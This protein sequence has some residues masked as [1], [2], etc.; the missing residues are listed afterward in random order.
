MEI[1]CSVGATEKVDQGD[2]FKDVY[3][4][5]IDENVHAIVITPTC[6]LV[7]EK[8]DYIKFVS[9]I[10]LNE[11]IILI[12]KHKGIDSS[13]FQS[14]AYLSNTK[15][16]DLIDAFIQNIRGDLLP[17]FYFLD[18]YA[19]I[20]SA[21]FADLQQVFVVPDRLVTTEYLD[22]RIARLKSPWREEIVARYSGYSMRVGVPARSKDELRVILAKT[23]LN[24]TI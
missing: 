22:N 16:D 20:F 6:D 4:P 17:R 21:C 23:G 13:F 11:V 3:F 18:E 8:A 15:R 7:Q 2:V 9:V 19:G 5:A 24:F 12:A 1:Y 10:S 14:G